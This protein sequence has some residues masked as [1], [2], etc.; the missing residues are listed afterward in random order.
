MND[1]AMIHADASV[2]LDDARRLLAVDAEL[3]EIADR[4]K[5]LKAQRGQIEE[6]LAEAYALNGLQSVN[7]DGYTV[8][9]QTTYH[10][11]AIA[12]KRTELIDWAIENGLADFLKAPAIDSNRLKSWCVEQTKQEGS[13]P[14]ELDG[15]VSL[16]ERK[17]IRA[18]QSN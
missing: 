10:F 4:E 14:S 13:I 15:L 5:V 18:R 17:A 6:R 12:D 7:V 8:Y 16:Y 1:P 2:F 3:K 11:N 9:L